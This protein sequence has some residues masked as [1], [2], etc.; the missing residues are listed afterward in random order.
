VDVD[1]CG[2]FRAW[3]SSCDSDSHRYRNFG[4]APSY[5]L[6]HFPFAAYRH[7]CFAPAHLLLSSPVISPSYLL[8]IPFCTPILLHL[9]Q[10][11]PNP[12]PYR[13]MG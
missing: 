5:P 13:N 7:V 11:N 8:R 6:C 2:S 3:H 9:P 1:R 4:D 10:A 12:S